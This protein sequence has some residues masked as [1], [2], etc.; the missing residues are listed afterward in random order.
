M[1]LIGPQVRPFALLKRWL[2]AGTYISMVN[3]VIAASSAQIGRVM[4]GD[5]GREAPARGAAP[6]VVL[7]ATHGEALAVVPLADLKRHA[8]DLA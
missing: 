5:T 3:T 8:I 2:K 6:R 7:G 1:P 4:K